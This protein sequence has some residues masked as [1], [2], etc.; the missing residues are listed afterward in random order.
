MKKKRILIAPNSYKGVAS[1]NEAAE[2]FE[3]YLSKGNSIELFKKPVTD[4]GD[5]FLEVCLLN[6]DL[7]IYEFEIPAPFEGKY[8]K[9]K[10]GY[11]EKSH[12]VYIESADVL[13]M[14]VIPRAKRKPVELNSFGLGV[15]L[16]MLKRENEERRIIIEKVFIGIRGTGTNDLG[17]GAASAFGLNIF[18]VNGKPLKVI[19][20]NF[21]LI[22]DIQV[23]KIKLPFKIF[24]IVD[25][26]N[27]LIGKQ[28]STRVF[29][30]Q[31][32]C[33]DEDIKSIE[34]GFEK[35][36][37]ILKRKNYIKKS[38]QL[39]G[40]GGGLAA[41]LKIFFGA[42]Q[43]SA[44]NFILNYLGLKKY[45]D[46]VDYVITGEGIFDG[47]SLMKKAPGII[48]DFFRAPKTEIFLCCGVIEKTS[49]NKAGSGIIPVEF[50]SFWRS[51][52][53]SL[54]RFEESIRRSS[55]KILGYINGR[56][57]K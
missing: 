12:T 13:G 8:L 38:E 16:M 20:A 43:I 19:P 32:G 3:K 44:S 14:K 22:E 40:A 25:V 10:I 34:K 50:I 17:L 5:G 6:F 1:S 46:T 18:D 51:K 56:L 21:N 30:K 31:K 52:E 2:I 4:G 42:R 15:L 23:P 36:V 27:P 26:V 54:R 24:T 45:K 47:Q 37:K 35:I 11:N 9:C 53:E 28:G 57:Q 29:G 55:N 33:S 48:I 49:L 39:N 41:G 7:I